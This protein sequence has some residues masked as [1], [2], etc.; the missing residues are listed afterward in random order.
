MSRLEVIKMSLDGKTDWRFKKMVDVSGGKMTLKEVSQEIF[1]FMYHKSP[2]RLIVDIQRKKNGYH[3]TVWM[4]QADWNKPWKPSM[5]KGYW[6][7]DE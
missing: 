2:K 3:A 5:P 4:N 1:F 6:G 7:G